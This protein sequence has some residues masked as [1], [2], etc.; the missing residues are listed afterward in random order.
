MFGKRCPSRIDG[1]GGIDKCTVHVK[2]D[3]V[4]FDGDCFDHL[5]SE[6]LRP[7]YGCV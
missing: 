4:H 3:G 5:V 7:R 2:E 6:S 1:R